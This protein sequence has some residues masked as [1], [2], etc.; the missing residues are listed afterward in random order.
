MSEDVAQRNVAERTT[1]TPELVWWVLSR[2][3]PFDPWAPPSPAARAAEERLRAYLAE[4]D[5]PPTTPH[6]V[7]SVVTAHPLPTQR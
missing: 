2:F 6:R 7:A 3:E 5:P 4:V 1:V